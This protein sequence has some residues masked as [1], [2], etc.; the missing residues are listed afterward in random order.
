M[1]G[2]YTF[3][4]DKPLSQYKKSDTG[5]IV[6]IILMWGIGMGALYV[7]SSAYC[8]KVFG[9][10]LMLVKRQLLASAVGFAGLL[11]FAFAPLSKIRK[12]LPLIMLVCIVLLLATFVPAF[13][14]ERN[15]AK[16][17]VKL[18]F[19]RFQPSELAKFAVI[20]YLANFFDKYQRER[21]LEER[22]V[23]P[24]VVV[25]TLF[26]ALI[27]AEKDFSTGLFLFLICLLLFFISGI[28]TLWLV[29]MAVIGLPA[30]AMMIVWEP[31]RMERIA[32]YLHP[33]EFSQGVNYQTNASLRAIGAG[34]FWGQGIGNGL[35]KLNSIPEV[36]AD[37]IFAGWTEA[38][39][40]VGV[41]IYFVILCVF[42]YR[43]YKRA[44]MCPS[45]FG[46]I[47]T[48]GCISAILFQSLANVAVVC[49]AIPSTGIPLPF[50]SAGGSSMIVT[51]CMC[52][53]MINAARGDENDEGE[54]AES[55]DDVLEVLNEAGEY[56]RL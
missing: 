45:R 4:P 44:F 1:M 39:G 8:G 46:A 33:E 42:A 37:Y 23:F 18:P 16:R 28:K 34:G 14:E 38:M 35:T 3:Y 27:F 36:Q 54:S 41:A 5:L 53:F 56:E 26:V 22:S 40:F 15:G 13:N 24:A 55:I 31:Y 32:G 9:N 21:D 7:C 48:F 19:F 25:M 12:I 43:A 11:F 20:L 30:L 52:G 29:P 2:G 10:E 6:S 17:W 51:L 50:F 47:G 49:G